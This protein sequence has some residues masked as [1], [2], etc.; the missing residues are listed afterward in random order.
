MS[1]S[2]AMMAGWK[3]H[4]LASSVQADAL[5]RLID[6]ANGFMSGT[7]GDFARV[8]RHYASAVQVQTGLTGGAP[9]MQ[10]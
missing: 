5:L 3:R 4:F 2:L 8:L 9:G 1:A 6:F 10:V 7:T